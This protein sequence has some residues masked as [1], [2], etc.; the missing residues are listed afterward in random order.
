MTNQQHSI[1][2]SHEIE[3]LVAIGRAQDALAL[4]QRA[5]QAP[6]ANA[7]DWLLYGCLSADLGDNSTG[8]LALEKAIELDPTLT[9]AYLGI[10]KLLI[11]AGDYGGAVAALQ[12]A[13]EL[14]VDSGQVWLALG[15]ACGLKNEVGDAEECCRRAVELLPGSAYALFNLANALQRQGRLVEAEVQYTAALSIEPALVGAWSM[16]AQT[17]IG[18]RNFAAAE[19][20]A[21]QA[22]ALDPGLGEAHFTLARLLQTRGEISAARDHFLRAANLLPELPDAHV[23]LAQIL[24]YLGEYAEAAECYRRALSLNSALAPAHCLLGECLQEQKLLAEA[25]ASYRRALELDNDYAR[26][27]NHLA[28]LLLIR[29]RNAE[30][31]EHFA[32]IVRI[33][34]SNEHAKHMLA[35]QRGETTVA[36]PADYVA[37]LF[38]TYADTFDSSLVDKLNYR[39]PELLCEMVN[40]HLG[41]AAKSLDVI[42]LGCGT[43]LCAPLFR[44]MARHLSGVDLAPRMIE[45]ARDRK[46]YDELEVGDIGVTL[47]SKTA[48]WDLAI[49]ADV[50]VYLGDLHETFIA[51]STA[52]K[53]GGLLA[54]SVEASDDSEAYVLRQT[55]RYAHAT[56]YIKSLAAASGFEE[57]MR[58]AVFLR[59]EA[60]RKMAGYIFLLRRPNDAPPNG[61]RKN[62]KYLF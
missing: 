47:K 31:A 41:S 37:G 57:I 28:H 49:A 19:T 18:L 23:R 17:R 20:A 1:T 62:I 10:G 51:C 33:E 53:P 30:A 61:Y 36:A 4:S 55:G 44:N 12:K 60:G 54:F 59:Q 14:D 50:F 16:L 21:M 5:C 35:A 7:D 43:G 8:V 40:Q 25:E 24:Q 38:D 39:T 26:A 22:L 42:D 15:I 2:P 9:E 32:E 6:H 52:L 56:G 27:H 45:K 58:R 46:L 29:S 34:P 48:Q 13:A 3:Q 11:A